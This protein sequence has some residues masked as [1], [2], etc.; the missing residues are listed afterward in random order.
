[1]KALYII[2]CLL[3]GISIIAEMVAKQRHGEAMQM[4]AKAGTAR[5]EVR[6]EATQHADALVRAGDRVSVGGLISAGA[7][8]VLWG[9]SRL[10]GNSWTQVLPTALAAGYVAMWFLV[11]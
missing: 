5:P 3:L 11:V 6:Q 10:K 9:V 8:V 7:G 2:A 1:M 4:V